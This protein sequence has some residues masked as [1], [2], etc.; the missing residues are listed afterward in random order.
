VKYFAY[1]TLKRGFPNYPL[2]KY[3]DAEFIC[4]GYLKGYIMYSLGGFPMIDIGDKNNLIHGEIFEVNDFNRLDI[5]E[6]TKT[7]FYKRVILP[8][9][10]KEKT[11]YCNVYIKGDSYRIDTKEIIKD[12]IWKR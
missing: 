12:G 5:L 3:I 4:E 1:G 7:G 11:I 2:M 10:C 6:G 9:Q 8:I